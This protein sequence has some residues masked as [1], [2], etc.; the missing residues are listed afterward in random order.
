MEEEAVDIDM[1]DPE[2][3]AAATKIQAGFKGHKA[4]Q[5]V[6]AMKVSMCDKF[7][8]ICKSLPYPLVLIS[9][10]CSYSISTDILSI[11]HQPKPYSRKISIFAN[12]SYLK[13]LGSCLLILFIIFMRLNFV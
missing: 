10:V 1:N 5:E 12:S 4:R 13:A 3:A 2:V 9:N 8:L 11:L 6:K 7:S